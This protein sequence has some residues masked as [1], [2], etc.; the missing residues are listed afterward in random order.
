[1]RYRLANLLFRLGLGLLPRGRVSAELAAL[2]DVWHSRV[3]RALRADL[4]RAPTS[5]AEV[6]VAVDQLEKDMRRYVYDTVPDRRIA[7][8]DQY[9]SRLGVSP[10]S[11]ESGQ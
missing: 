10:W 1:M 5:T 4:A 2:L 7:C 3:Q 9:R 8:L 6:V 11:E